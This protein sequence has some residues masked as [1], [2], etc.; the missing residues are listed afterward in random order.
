MS[1]LS[2]FCSLLVFSLSVAGG[3]EGE[4]DM[5]VDS[6]VERDGNRREEVG[7]GKRE[8]IGQAFFSTCTDLYPQFNWLKSHNSS[9]T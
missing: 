8:G 1:I 9:T 6:S 5:A 3:V 4:G 7:G 2:V